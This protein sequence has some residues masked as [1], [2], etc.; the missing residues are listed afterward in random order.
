MVVRAYPTEC[1]GESDP[2]ATT[3]YLG[4]LDKHGKTSDTFQEGVLLQVTN[5]EVVN[6]S[7]F[8]K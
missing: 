1:T 2:K 8:K 5:E 4:P 3:G 7:I 6:H